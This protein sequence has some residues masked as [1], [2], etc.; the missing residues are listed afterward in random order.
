MRSTFKIL[1]YVKRS[2][3]KKDGTAPIIARITVNGKISQLNTKQFIKPSDWSV[4]L[5][6]AKGRTFEA[7]TTNSILEEIK[8][9]IHKTYNELIIKE[10]IVTSEKIKNSFLGIDQKQY[11]LMELFEESNNILKTQVGIT[12]SKATYQK[13]EVCRRHLSSYIN[14][15][16]KI[17]DIDVREINHS[18]IITGYI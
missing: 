18:F 3:I 8:T 10:T 16:H 4:K 7:R 2:A 1:F 5:G 14:A 17:S 12:K 6:K 15:K 11:L 13:A 9:S